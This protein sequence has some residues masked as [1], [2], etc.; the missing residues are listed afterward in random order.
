MEQ[1]NCRRCRDRGVISVRHGIIYETDDDEEIA[2]AYHDESCPDW[3]RQ[4]ARDA[5]PAL[6]FALEWLVNHSE[7]ADRCGDHWSNSC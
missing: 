2:R 1:L 7:E 4:R 3:R 5:A 6:Y